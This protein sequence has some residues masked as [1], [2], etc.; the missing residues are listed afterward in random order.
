MEIVDKFKVIMIAQLTKL[1]LVCF[2]SAKGGQDHQ[3]N[4]KLSCYKSHFEG[5]LSPFA[6]VFVSVVIC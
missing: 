5:D 4:E 1:S 3:A 6:S 2:K